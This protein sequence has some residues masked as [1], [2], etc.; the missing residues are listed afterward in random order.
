MRTFERTE[1]EHKKSAKYFLYNCL[2]IRVLVRGFFPVFLLLSIALM[3]GLFAGEVN[4]NGI[5]Q[6]SVD[7]QKENWAPDGWWINTFGKKVEEIKYQFEYSEP[8]ANGNR[9]MSVTAPE[10]MKNFAIYATEKLILPIATGDKLTFTGEAMGTGR[11]Q[12]GYYGY[13]TI[14]RS[15]QLGNV[16]LRPEFSPFSFEFEVKD[17][18]G[19]GSA[20]IRPAINFGAG[21]KVRIRDLKLDLQRTNPDAVARRGFRYYPVYQ[22]SETPLLDIAKDQELWEKIP[23]SKGFVIHKTNQW[24]DENRQTSFKMAHDKK[25][26]YLLIRCEEPAMDDIRFNNEDIQ[27]PLNTVEFGISSCRGCNGTPH[28]WYCADTRGSSHSQSTGQ[29][30]AE[31]SVTI[32]KG[33]DFWQAQLA[34]ELAGLLHNKEQLKFNQDYFFNVGRADHPSTGTI[35]SSFAPSG[36]GTPDNFTVLSFFDHAP[37]ASEAAQDAILNAPY[38]AYLS[39]T[40]RQ[41]AGK[42]QIAWENDYNNYGTASGDNLAQALELSEK[43]KV[44]KTWQQWR[45]V[46]AEFQALDK[47]LRSPITKLTMKISVPEAVKMLF[48]NG[49][50]ILLSKDGIA[51]FPIIQGANVLAAEVEPGKKLIFAI[52]KHPETL[53]RWRGADTVENQN[54]KSLEFDDRKWEMVQAGNDGSFISPACIRQILFWEQTYYSDYRLTFPL[55]QWNFARDGMEQMILFLDSPLPFSLEQF[56]ITWDLPLFIKLLNKESKLYTAVDQS[57]SPLAGSHRYVYEYR[58]QTANVG[59]KKIRKDQLIFQTGTEMPVGTEFSISYSRA[60]GNFVELTQTLPCRVLPEVNGKLARN[61]QW[62]AG[63]FLPVPVDVHYDFCVQL[64]KAGLNAYTYYQIPERFRKESTEYPVTITCNTCYPMDGAGWGIKG[65][66]YEYV[67]KTPEAQA[68]FFD[69]AIV[70]GGKAP[71]EFPRYMDGRETTRFCLSFASNEGQN[72]FRRCIRED[73]SVMLRSCPE[74]RV[75]WNNW[76][77]HAGFGKME[78]CFCPRCKSDFAKSIGLSPE[79]LLSNEDIKN[80]YAKEWVHFQH[81]LDGKVL[82]LV[83]EAVQGLG[84]QF[85]AYNGY[86]NQDA[87]MEA[88]GK[89]LFNPGCPGNGQVTSRNQSTLDNLAIFFRDKCAGTTVAMGQMILP[90]IPW[91]GDRFDYCTDPDGFFTPETL[92]AALVRSAAALHGGS[93]IDASMLVGSLYFIGEGTRLITAYESLFHRGERDDALVKSNDIAYP[94]ALVLVRKT[95]FRNESE[96]RLVLLFNEEQEARTVTID[97]LKLGENATAEIWESGKE[98]MVTPMQMTVTIP[99]RDVTAIYIQNPK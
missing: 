79:I 68:H 30:E 93:R 1:A 54:W 33:K 9:T 83:N 4:I 84:M 36:F 41:I 87:W 14:P 18:S 16:E 73:V 8:D 43:A 31:F 7:Q 59:D 86:S 85:M 29:A 47:K 22:L 77:R 98:A 13:K 66:L 2:Q 76:E 3:N 81:I 71:Q 37:D 44:A 72:E 34:F 92:K 82:G 27:K 40:V 39:G 48:V 65:A 49:S 56:T 57:P 89:I 38:Y 78:R 23:E 12:V 20:F 35:L 24:Q 42:N 51:T 28:A 88:N 6:P 90:N 11:L 55:R 46:V 75:F 15:G 96:E 61:I 64:R 69:P 50:E 70:W 80:T 45:V 25:K 32:Q 60:A 91:A 19:D 21:A 99:P 94:N 74:A 53:G 26:L 67:K 58:D 52:E 95:D 62:S 17:A 10:D 63:M 97:N 5:F